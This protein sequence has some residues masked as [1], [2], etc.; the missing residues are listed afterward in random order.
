M[1]GCKKRGVYNGGGY[2][3]VAQPWGTPW[4]QG[5]LSHVNLHD[6][7]TVTPGTGAGA[8][9]R[10]CRMR[11]MAIPVRGDVVQRVAR[12]PHQIGGHIM[13]SRVWALPPPLAGAARGAASPD[14]PLAGAGPPAPGGPARGTLTRHE[15]LP[16]PRKGASCASLTVYPGGVNPRCFRSQIQ[17]PIIPMSRV[18]AGHAFHENRGIFMEI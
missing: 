16:I 4:A 9:A 6:T 5:M 12:R 13:A 15:T 17:A 7:S 18:N 3:P 1:V 11:E 10:L 8:L 2:P 14:R